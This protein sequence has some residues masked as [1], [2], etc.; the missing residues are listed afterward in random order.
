VVPFEQM[1]IAIPTLL[2]P[3]PSNSNFGVWSV[4]C[5]SQAALGTLGGRRAVRDSGLSADD[6]W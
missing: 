4:R 3:S 1:T 5:G 2:R 6:G